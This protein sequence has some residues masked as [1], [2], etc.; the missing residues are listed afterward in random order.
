MVI[1]S[2]KIQQLDF[3]QRFEIM[4]G[5]ITLASDSSLDI[6]PDN[7]IGS[8]RVKLPRKIFVDRK[9]H[10]IGLKYI[11]FPLKSHNVED[12]KL[13]IVFFST[14]NLTERLPLQFDTEIETGHYESPDDL[15]EALNGAL[16]KIPETYP[17]NYNSIALNGVNLD[18][19][20][21]LFEYNR[22]TEKITINAQET[23]YYDISLRMSKELFVKLGIGLEEEVRFTDGNCCRFFPLPREGSHTVDL[24]VGRSSIFVY[25]DVIEADRVVGHRLVPLLAIVPSVGA[26]GQQCYYEPRSIEYCTPRYDT[27]D[28][29]LIEL[30]GDTGQIMKFTSGKVYLTLRIKDRFEQ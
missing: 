12:G 23:E 5:H 24:D 9:R 19:S 6:F 10:Q 15:V 17:V 27:F 2:E 3:Y 22:H 21:V 7:K 1:L 20:F 30:T 11:S 13:S 4:A 29:I 14:S 8:F 28:E 26:H 25:T 16:A 18:Q